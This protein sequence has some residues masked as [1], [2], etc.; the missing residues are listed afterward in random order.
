MHL[1]NKAV[2]TVLDCNIVLSQFEILISYCVG[3]DMKLVILKLLV[4]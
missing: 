2:A 3:K 4:K 1:S